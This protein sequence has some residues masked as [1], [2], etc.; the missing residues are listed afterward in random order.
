MK[1]EQVY[2]IE[3]NSFPNFPTDHNENAIYI[4][5]RFKNG[6][7]GVHVD[8]L[9]TPFLILVTDI[10]KIYFLYTGRPARG[11][12]ALIFCPGDSNE[13]CFR[14]FVKFLSQV[15][16]PVHC[17]K[18]DILMNKTPVRILGAGGEPVIDFRNGSLF[19]PVI[20]NQ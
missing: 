1:A 3:M 18:T 13:S 17:F 5:H 6:F 4:D 20:P 10:T 14:V 19:S 2:L 7:F 15:L 16:G 9:N 12:P 11:R 8:M